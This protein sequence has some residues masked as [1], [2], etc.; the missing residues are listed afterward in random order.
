MHIPVKQEKIEIQN[1]PSLTKYLNTCLCF[2]T[3]CQRRYRA[4]AH[5]TGKY[6]QLPLVLT[7]CPSGL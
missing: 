7:H 2:V 1:P 5:Q 3:I 4:E 6:T